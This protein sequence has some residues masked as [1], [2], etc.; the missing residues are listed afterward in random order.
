[1]T[2]VDDTPLFQISI[3]DD[4]IGAFDKGLGQDW[5]TA[6][7][8]LQKA[9]PSKVEY[10]F[11]EDD[12][13]SYDWSNQIITLTPQAS[14][15]FL[16]NSTAILNKH[17]LDY[18]HGYAFVTVYESTPIYGGIFMPNIPIATAYSYPIIYPDIVDGQILFKIRSR[19]MDFE[20]K[21]DSPEWKRI[22][23]ERVKTLFERLGKLAK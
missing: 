15:N 6:W 19:H 7:P 2:V 13:E 17:S 18:I 9:Y 4:D 10:S 23:D 8:T 21:H 5:E 22:K 11:T 1:M 20:T 3:L 14:E 16:K 12:I